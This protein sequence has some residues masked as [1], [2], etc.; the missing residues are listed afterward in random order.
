MIYPP[1]DRQPVVDVL[2]GRAVRDPYRWLEDA[3]DPATVAWSAAQDELW[4]A[5][6]AALPDRDV[7]L[8]RVRELSAAGMVGAPVWRGEHRFHL[9]RH[10]AENHPVL[11]RDGSPLLDPNLL[12]PSGATVLDAWQP[13]LEGRLM[14][15]QVSRGGDERSVMYVVDTASGGLVEGP[16]EGCRY[17]PVA[18]LPGGASFYYVRSRAV[19]LH[20]VG[21][22][23][24]E[25]L[26]IRKDDASYGLA[27]S[28]DGRWLVVSAAYGS[29]NDVWLADLR[30]TG[31]ERPLLRAVQEEGTPARTA[32]HVG[33]DGRLYLVTDLDA[34]RGRLCVADPAG[35]GDW[36]DLVPEDGEAVLAGY[37]V[38]D[39][40]A[41]ERPLLL[42]SRLRD[43]VAEL[44]LHDLA[45][46]VR[47]REIDLPGLGS[48]GPLGT[49]PEGCH[50]AWFTYTDHVTPSTVLRFDARDGSLT[51]WATAPGAVT[52]PAITTT[53]LEFRSA[54]GTLVPMVILSRPQ[55]TGPRP[56]ILYGYG[57]FG[58]PLSPAYSTYI[59]PWLAAGGVFAL[60]GVRGGGER[61][62]EWH[63]AGSR[64]HKHN[65]F[66]D[67]TAA[68]QTL[69]A[70][71]W[72]TPDQLGACGESNGGLL[73]AAAITRRPDLFSA[74]VCSA[75]LTDMV[76]YERS[77]MGPAW[78]EE[79]GTACDPAELDWLLSYS[80]YHLVRSGQRYPATLFTV[81]AG[82]T[83]V[84][85]L[86]AR[87]M[88]AAMQ[89]AASGPEPVL[90]RRESGVGHGERAMSSGIELAADLLAFLAAHT[91]L[92]LE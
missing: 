30:D 89:R 7:A 8:A 29:R 61:G 27:S 24:A 48:I 31:P 79:Y 21:T 25:D 10:A 18:W 86:H 50:E 53:R 26:Q 83:R 74:A 22:P 42:V 82:D 12:D 87:K 92:R 71:R 23:V 63:R 33:R 78:R 19:W 65:S 34:P 43:A 47:L 55:D 49:R 57:G 62:Q 40:P 13:D 88:C 39:G 9:R 73:V 81:F 64:E 46:G 54:D 32:P 14:A 35:P 3:A 70:Q 56:A 68:A 5:H 28:A 58:L 66:D 69:I 76:R 84:D 59:L 20:R 2:H 51:T 77:G 17:S 67:F 1:A 90:L 36:H 80:P 85:P 44:S 45:T 6:A 52:P 4:Q 91:G 75:P 16:I 38:L 37:A 11:Y 60:A 41:L 15:V 72:T